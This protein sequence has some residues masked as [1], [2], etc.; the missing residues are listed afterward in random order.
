MCTEIQNN[1]VNEL[2]SRIPSSIYI[3]NC[4]VSRL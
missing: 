4:K 1:P 3:F 2:L